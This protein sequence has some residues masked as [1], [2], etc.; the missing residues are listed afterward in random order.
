MVQK[1]SLNNYVIF[2]VGPTASGKTALASELAKRLKSVVISADSV[3]IYKGLNIGS[4]KPTDEEKNIAPHKLIDI[5]DPCDEFSVAEYE[6]LG[7]KEINYLFS[8]KKIP[9]VCGGTG[10]YVDSLLYKKSYGNCTKNDD[11]RIKLNKIYKEKGAV[12]LHG[13]LHEVDQDS[14]EKLHVNDVFRVSRALEIFYSTGKKKSEINDEIKPR[15]KYFS[16]SF[17]YP[18]DVLYSRINE[19]VDKMFEKGLLNEV[20]NLLDSGVKKNAQS[21]RAIGYKEVVEGLENCESEREIK[22]KIK[23]NSRRFAKR[24]ITYFKRMKN[25]VYLKNF[26]INAAADEVMDCIKNEHEGN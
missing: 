13:M 12:Y 19:R 8:I 5:A 24:Q 23:L 1:D 10:Y 15:F 18:R 14:A 22:E 3:S 26:D 11:I 17:D 6:N 7:L 20:K 25:L 2:V 9:V 16:F 21:M 4:A